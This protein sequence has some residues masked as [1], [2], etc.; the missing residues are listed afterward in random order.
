MFR[1]KK[2]IAEK[3]STTITTKLHDLRDKITI[4]LQKQHTLKMKSEQLVA[5]LNDYENV[6]NALTG[7]DQIRN[8]YQIEHDFIS[9]MEEKLAVIG[10]KR[11]RCFSS[12]DLETERTKLL[13]NRMQRKKN[14]KYVNLRNE[15]VKRSSV[16]PELHLWYKEL[17]PLH[18]LDIAMQYSSKDF[19]SDYEII[20]ELSGRVMLAKNTDGTLCVLKRFDAEQERSML[21]HAAAV[22]SKLSWHPNVIKLNAVVDGI[23]DNNI[24][25][26]HPYYSHGDLIQ[27]RNSDEFNIGQLPKIF[28]DVIQGLMALHANGIIHRD[29]KPQNVLVS[30]NGSVLTDFDLSEFQA[31]QTN[32]TKHATSFTPLTTNFAAPEVLMYGKHLEH[33]DL[34]SLGLTFGYILT[35]CPQ[36][37]LKSENEFSNIE[38]LSSD[39]KQLISG[40]IQLDPQT[41]TPLKELLKNP[42][43]RGDRECSVCFETKMLHDGLLCQPSNCHFIC[44]YCFGNYIK[45]E[46]AKDAVLNTHDEICCPSMVGC[47]Q[48]HFPFDYIC[49]RTSPE[50]IA[51]FMNWKQSMI[52]ARAK[53]DERNRLNQV[54]KSERLENEVI[55][56][57]LQEALLGQEQHSRI[58]MLQYLRTE[59]AFEED[60]Y[61]RQC[62]NC[63]RVVQK[64]DGCNDVK[65]GQD[66]HGGNTQFGCSTIFSFRDA[67]RYKSKVANLDEMIGELSSRPT[68]R[69]D[70]A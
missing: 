31:D 50:I 22:L 53:E 8:E 2:R 4:M 25:L 38:Y 1:S 12:R 62:P 13:N 59:K 57:K 11:K 61:T 27:W 15:L 63:K 29:I 60:E 52:A 20:K 55:Y 23:S 46:S 69:S 26:E 7:L 43:I 21:R 32:I 36:V 67:P 5:K 34:Y 10:V 47:N 37:V 51:L 70:L 16:L 28:F 9:E 18:D 49:Q 41:R 3:W 14:F 56:K 64:I 24:F 42:F 35:G 30:P 58:Q 65:C 66:Y 45:Q 17:D 33:S 40:L 19:D 6:L 68:R 44:L 54:M 39:E 48:G